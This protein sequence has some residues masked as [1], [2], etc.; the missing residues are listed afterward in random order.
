MSKAFVGCISVEL[1]REGDMFLVGTLADVR[2][3]IY[4]PL[5]HTTM[6][7]MLNPIYTTKLT[8]AAAAVSVPCRQLTVADGSRP[9]FASTLAERCVR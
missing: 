7:E 4:P 3:F 9:G 1:V 2:R 8:E 5:R 6:T